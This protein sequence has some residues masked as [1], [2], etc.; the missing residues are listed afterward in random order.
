M[1][2]KKHTNKTTNRFKDSRK[3]ISINTH[4]FKKTYGVATISRLLEIVSIF[5][6]IQSLLQGSFAKVT[7]NFKEPTNRSHPISTCQK[8]LIHSHIYEW[9]RSIPLFCRALLQKRPI[10]LRSLRIVA[11]PYLHVKRDWSIHTYMS[12]WGRFHELYETHQQN[13]TSTHRLNETHVHWHT[14]DKRDMSTHTNV[15]RDILVHTY[16]KRDIYAHTYVKRDVSIHTYPLTHTCQKR[17]IYSHI[18]ECVRSIPWATRSRWHAY[19][20][21]FIIIWV[22]T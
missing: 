15:K 2:Y 1:G 11:T 3:H 14:C 5:C 22:Y 12:E 7:C 8:R 20:N 9:V 18:N 17:R 19:I 13:Y 6:R 16:V 21:G 4:K 10:I